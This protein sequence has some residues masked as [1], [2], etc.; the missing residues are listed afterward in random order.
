MIVVIVENY[1]NIRFRVLTIVSMSL[2][3][4]FGTGTI[5]CHRHLQQGGG[6]VGDLIVLARS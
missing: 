6:E 3:S 4:V 1:V 2:S 5:L